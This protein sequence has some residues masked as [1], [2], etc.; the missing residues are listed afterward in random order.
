MIFNDICYSN[1]RDYKTL[2]VSH[3]INSECYI[4]ESNKYQV[5]GSHHINRCGQCLELIGPTQK[6]FICMIAGTFR[7]K[8]VT[9]LTL[10]DLQ[11][12]VFVSNTVFNY[13]GT[14]I[15]GEINHGT[16]ISVRETT[17]PF[18]ATPSVSVEKLI[19]ATEYDEE[20][21]ELLRRYAKVQI[22]NSNT[23]HKVIIAGD[24]EYEI[25]NDA[26]YVIPSVTQTFD[27]VSTKTERIR[28]TNVSLKEVGNV[29][30]AYEQFTILDQ[31]ENNYNCYYLP[32]NN[33]YNE[34][35]LNI[36][37]SPVKQY[38]YWKIQLEELNT[39]RIIQFYNLTN[40]NKV[41]F[42]NNLNCHLLFKYQSVIQMKRTFREFDLTF[43]FKDH[44]VLENPFLLMVDYNGKIGMDYEIV[45]SSLH[46]KTLIEKSNTTS[47]LHVRVSFNNKMC[48]AFS[49]II[50]FN[51]TTFDHSNV[52]LIEAKLVYQKDFEN[53][54]S[55]DIESFNC[56]GMECIPKN[57]TNVDCNPLCGVCAF[58]TI[59]NDDGQCV[60]KTQGDS[61][62]EP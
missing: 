26:S 5:I 22:I 54:S 12:T 60:K 21:N 53:L 41:E 62:Y 27:L 50:G 33:V 57:Y 3:S 25:Q 19:V 42:L 36:S 15:H 20:G 37:S 49:N 47:L 34:S 24:K 45:C 35:M 56:N 8:G 31:Y 32:S 14:V 30:H 46:M 2:S 39:H 13:I 7:E 55:C 29:F 28:F 44:F 23:L 6:P 61:K 48:N 1:I 11:R 17:C 51:F 16:Q 38:F 43:E 18:Y 59:C 10:F 52:R 40:T 9:N 58:G 4:Y